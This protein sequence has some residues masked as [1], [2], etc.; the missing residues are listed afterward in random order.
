VSFPILPAKGAREFTNLLDRLDRS[1]QS[2][3]TKKALDHYRKEAKDVLAVAAVRESLSQLGRDELLHLLRHQPTLFHLGGVLAFDTTGA[4]ESVL[5]RLV[6]DALAVI[7]AEAMS[8]SS[9][10]SR[11]ELTT[12]LGHWQ[13]VLAGAGPAAAALSGRVLAMQSALF[14]STPAGQLLTAIGAEAPHDRL[15]TFSLTH[16]A[17]DGWAQVTGSN[18][19]DVRVVFAVGQTQHLLVD[20]GQICEQTIVP[21]LD[22]VSHV[23]E[24]LDRCVAAAGLAPW[25][26]S[27]HESTVTI[28]GFT[29]REKKTIEAWWLGAPVAKQPAKPPPH[30][31]FDAHIPRDASQSDRKALSVAL[32]SLEKLDVVPPKAAQ[33]ARISEQAKNPLLVRTLLAWLQ[34]SST[35]DTPHLY[36]VAIAA[37][38]GSDGAL[39]VVDHALAQVVGTGDLMLLWN[40]LR[41]VSEFQPTRPMIAVLR[42][43][44][45]KRFAPTPGARLL[46]SMGVSPPTDSEWE[47]VLMARQPH[48]DTIIEIYPQGFFRAEAA[49]ESP[50]TIPQRDPSAPIERIR[51]YFAACAREAGFEPWNLAAVWK[52]LEVT[53]GAIV[54]LEGFS[55]ED[56]RKITSWFRD[57]PAGE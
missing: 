2:P 23:R 55:R 26:W 56:A 5:A 27:P 40:Y 9:P 20:A 6:D 12:A 47:V 21:T 53:N 3:G 41:I 52:P 16:I 30:T 4:S 22:D 50:R 14:P 11:I 45:T 44:W 25:G 7:D 24:H 42:D 34:A 54:Q 19:G 48:G 37:A 29:P 35:H 15:A 51:E 13:R 39:V 32:R 43:E 10:V 46:R 49:V 31:R 33:R 36:A 17:P 18:G 38:E 1:R 8:S 57:W 28:V